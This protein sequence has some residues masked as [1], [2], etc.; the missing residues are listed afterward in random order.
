LAPLRDGSTT[1]WPNQSDVA[2]S[3]AVTRERVGQIVADTTERW[4]KLAALNV[5]RDEIAQT[6]KDEGGVMTV[7]ELVRS[8][9]ASSPENSEV[10]ADRRFSAIARA[11]VETE[12]TA[13]GDG[14][15]VR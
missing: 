3:V 9:L 14:G 5:V 10:G 15:P 7:P 11:A 4:A 8:L 6:L 13:E 12:R 2:S 1:T